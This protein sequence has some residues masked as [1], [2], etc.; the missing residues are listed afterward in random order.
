MP[1]IGPRYR[2]FHELQQM[3]RPVPVV[4]EVYARTSITFNGTDE[5]SKHGDVLGFERTQPFSASY[6][7]KTADVSGYIAS[8]M[9]GTAN[10]RGWGVAVDPTR[11][12]KI[13]LRNNDP[14]GNALEAR[15]D[16]A[17][18]NNVWTHV[19]TTYNGS[20]AVAGVK[21]YVNGVLSGTV[22]LTAGLTATILNTA[23]FNIN[24]R[25][26]GSVLLTALINE[27]GVWNKALSLAEAVA[28]YRARDLRQLPFSSS[29]VGYWS[30]DGSSGSLMP[31]YSGNG[32]NGTPVNMAAGNFTADVHTPT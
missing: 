5:Y 16:V 3:Q 32:Y 21:F 2:N 10:F 29:L 20:S 22:S 30:G 14:A 31:D 9:D 28:V 19:V 13:F 24:G 26:N 18:G 4:S 7:V 17:C 25:T 23:E 11:Y 1:L 15:G 6:W 8:K 12:P 27:V